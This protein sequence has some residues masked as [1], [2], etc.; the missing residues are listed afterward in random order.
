MI[1]GIGGKMHNALAPDPSRTKPNQE[2]FLRL[3]TVQLSHQDPLNP[4][5]SQAFIEQLATFSS[6]EE[7]GNIKHGLDAL[8]MAQS[9]VV[10]A[11]A[12]DFAGRMATIE[13]DSFQLNEGLP[14]ERGAYV[15][16]GG[17][18]TVTIKSPAGEVV[19]TMEL[20]AQEAGVVHFQWDG[21]NDDGDAV[22]ASNYQFE[23]SATDG[24]ESLRASALIRAPVES[25]SFDRGYA[26]LRIMGRRYPLGAILEIGPADAGAEEE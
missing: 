23:V 10:S 8:A 7:L 19:K 6:L 3:L 12:V 5:D 25:V 22:P 15:P 16:D 13:R 26:E 21:T 2:D 20:G 1:D 18:L 24:D 4:A 9:S 14:A 11:S 17:N